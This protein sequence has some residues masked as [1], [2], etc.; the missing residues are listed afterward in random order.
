VAGPG[1]REVGRIAIRVLP[2]TSKFSTSLQSYLDRIERRAQVKVKAVADTSRFASEM[3]ADLSRVRARIEVPVTPN[4]SD[5]ADRV[6]TELSRTSARV[7]VPVLPDTREFAARLRTEIASFNRPITVPV[8]PDVSRF[9]QRVYSQ[10]RGP[11]RQT[12]LLVGLLPDINQ[13]RLR[14]ERQLRAIRASLP[15]LVTPNFAGFRRSLRR[16]LGD[17]DIELP[18]VLAVADGEIARLRAELAGIRP[19]LAVPVRFDVDRSATDQLQSSLRNLGQTAG[20]VAATAA[21]IAA[22]G[23]AASV[24]IPAV[25]GLVAT[26]AQIAPAAAVGA[27]AVLAVVAANAALK[28]GMT[29]VEEALKNAF[30]PENAE[31]FNEA[32]KKLTPNA[33][34]FVLAIQKLGPEFSKIRKA[35]QERLFEGLG[36]Q[37]TKTGKVALPVLRRGLEGAAGALNE[38]G[39]GVL[40]ATEEL[41]ESGSLG[42]AV[43]GATKGLTNLKDVP[44]EIVKSLTGLAEAASPAFDRITKAV[45]RV[46]KRMSDSIARGVDSGQL[47]KSIDRAI[48]KIKQIGRVGKNIGRTLMN[49]FQ[50]AETSGVDFLSVLEQIT[51]QL[52][53]VTGSKGAQD[54]LKEVFDTLAEV[55]KSAGRLLLAA[56]ESIAPAVKELGPP[57]KQVVKDLERGLEP[58]IRRL[59]PILK[60]LAKNLGGVAMELSPFLGPLGELIGM[61]LGGLQPILRKVGEQAKLLAG[62]LKRL[63]LPAWEK[64]KPVLEPFV[65][66][67]GRLVAGFIE[68]QNQILEK[69]QPAFEEIGLAFGM[70]LDELKP[71][72][73]E[74]EK[75]VNETLPKLKPIIDPIIDTVG[76]LVVIFAHGLARVMR[77]F[78]IPAIEGLVALLQ[79]DFQTAWTKAGEI[80]ANGVRFIG[81]VLAKLPSI[82][83]KILAHLSLVLIGAISAAMGEFNDWVMRGMN[84]AF[85]EFAKLPGRAARA[86]S[87]LGWEVS[88][89]ARAEL[90]E[91]VSAVDRKIKEAVA[92]VASLPSRASAALSGARSYLYSAGVNLILGMVDGILS[93]ANAIADA[94]RG[95]VSRAIAAAKG[96]LGINSPSKVF[97]KIGEQTGEGFVVGLN[98]MQR[99]VAKSMGALVGVP[100]MR[101]ST[102]ANLST[103]VA[104]GGDRVVEGMLVLD[105][106][107]LM[108]KFQ[109]V[110]IE[111]DQQLVSTLRA[112]R[113]G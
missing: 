77:E 14:L 63:L 10:L 30:D 57:V 83:G 25:A 33:Q 105:S 5:F 93:R 76:E 64:L 4:T 96:A 7:R 2:D 69:L 32:L 27:T 70:V 85:G 19:P 108:G 86:L 101:L 84:R 26:L 8:E 107:E 58:V 17:I 42:R 110:L 9:E 34:K 41:S 37:V 90:S 89:M 82:V 35:V 55:G 95:V 6:R 75:F 87:S 22:V 1:G 18:V 16:E 97:A 38:M 59:G 61:M 23:A 56:L 98:G 28:V 21:A 47:Q 109:G 74:L 99:D 112:G 62:T 53:K 103:V 43:D 113:K 3:R 66:I 50:P 29:G 49:L 65:R 13:F 106:G 51:G 100:S 68:L 12:R 94:A 31:A 24:A 52:A 39:K 20:R 40:Q 44:G 36:D 46:S 88:A 72:G 80:A 73:A 78:V 91:L 81:D 102:M 15:V 104:G 54:T 67:T 79:G 11:L 48:D 71:L 92:R 45:D 111:H 60:D